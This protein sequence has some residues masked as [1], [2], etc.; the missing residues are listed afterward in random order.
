M[1]VREMEQ[2]CGQKGS[3]AVDTVYIGGGT[4]STMGAGDAAFLMDRIRQIFSVSSG[5]EITME[6]NPCDMTPEFLEKTRR[7]GINRISIGIQAFQDDLLKKIGRRHTAAEGMQ[8]VK[9]AWKAGYRNI[10]IDLMYDLP[11]QSPEDFRRSLEKAVHLP[12]THLSVY[13]LIIEEGTPFDRWNRMGK[14]LRPAEEDSWRMYQMMCRILPHYGF[15]RYEISS[16][17]RPGFQSVHNKKYWTGRP[18]LGIG[19][20]AVSFMK[21]E[22]WKNISSLKRYEECLTEGKQ[23]DREREILTAA[24]RMEEYCFLHL[25]M[26]EGIPRTAFESLFGHPPETWYRQQIQFLLQAGLLEEKENFLRMT[27]RG[28]ALGNFVFEQFIRTGQ[29]EDR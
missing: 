28:M 27:P 29:E 16:F 13:S 21:G 5:A 7:L 6:M 2:Y 19:P 26:T 25:R 20:S 1:A 18:W 14:L 17:A 23:P 15:G 11:G 24:E 4:P 8:A 22:R 3:P 9:R 12:I 10:S